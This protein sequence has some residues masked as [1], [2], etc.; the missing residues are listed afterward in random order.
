MATTSKWRFICQIILEMTTH[1]F[2]W[3][4][5]TGI[6]KL[7]F[8]SLTLSRV[9]K[10]LKC[11]MKEIWC[12]WHT[13]Y[14]CLGGGAAVWLLTKIAFWPQN[15]FFQCKSINSLG[16]FIDILYDHL[17]KINH[18]G[19]QQVAWF[20]VYHMSIKQTLQDYLFPERQSII[21]YI[22]IQNVCTVAW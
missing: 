19:P 5:L 21:L 15:K 6:T 11:I 20:E 2:F 18:T 7:F 17:E 1:T 22:M 4:L 3:R 16:S 9:W 10:H 8:F 13:L 14:W 12:L